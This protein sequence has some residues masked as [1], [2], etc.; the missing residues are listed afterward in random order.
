MTLRTG[1]Y[2]HRPSTVM[3]RVANAATQIYRYNRDGAQPAV[4]AHALERGIYLIVSNEPIEVTAD[5]GVDIVASKGKDGWPEFRA[6]VIA[7]EFGATAESIRSF[8]SVVKGLD[9]VE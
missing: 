7:L 6:E 3:I 9:P 8:F 2:V 1:L 5:N 4:G